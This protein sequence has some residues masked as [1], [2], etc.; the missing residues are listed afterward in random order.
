MTLS[1][2]RNARNTLLKNLGIRNLIDIMDRNFLELDEA[3]D[4]DRKKAARYSNR[5]RGSVRVNTGRFYTVKEHQ[6][7]IKK[8]KQLKLP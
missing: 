4:I 8:A 2:S 5:N 3:H 7:R 1:I 6:R